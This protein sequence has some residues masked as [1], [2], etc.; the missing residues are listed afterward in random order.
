MAEPAF[1]LLLPEMEDGRSW[2]AQGE[3]TYE[4]YLRLP[5]DGN[6]YEV[7][8][9]RLYASPMPTYDH[10][11]A[12]MQ[13]SLLLGIFVQ[14]NALGVL[15]GAP[16]DVR[17]P[18][19]IA[20]PV[21]P[22]LLFIRSENEPRSGDTFFAGTPDLVIEVLSR[23]TRRVDQTLKFG[24][25]RDAGVPEYWMVDPR[26]RTVVIYRL[27]EDGQSYVEHDRGGEGD[28]VGSAVLPGLRLAVSRLFPRR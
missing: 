12:V 22:D 4:D 27:S 24:A 13:L 16:F 21:E 23:S 9:G 1:S 11:F 20:N 6:R 8:R 25:Y 28:T 19:E 3:W 18:R 7:I 17:L 15:L 26:D 2:P 5:D 14:E 10:Q